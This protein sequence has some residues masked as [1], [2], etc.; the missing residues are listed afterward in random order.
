M[1]LP[2]HT[3]IVRF[4]TQILWPQGDGLPHCGILGAEK[5]DVKKNIYRLEKK[6]NTKNEFLRTYIRTMC[7]STLCV[8]EGVIII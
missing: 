2:L 8:N 3:C 5:I 6:I 7:T 4:L 1:L